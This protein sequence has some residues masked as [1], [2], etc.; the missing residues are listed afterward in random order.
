MVDRARA[1]RAARWV[2]AERQNRRNFT[3]LPA[4]LAPADA[5]EAYAAQALLQDLL[6]ETEGPVIGGK[7]ALTTPV[8]QKLTNYFHPVGAGILQR[9]VHWRTAELPLANYVRI[10]IECEVA[11]RLGRALDR[12]AADYTADSIAAAVDACMTGIEIVDDRA[13]DYGNL[14]AN[15]LIVDNA[16]NRGCVLATPV[17]DWRRLDLAKARGSVTIDGKEVGAGFGGDVMGAHPFASLA[18]LAN[19]AVKRGRPLAAG[20]IVLTGSLVVTQWPARG[21]QIVAAIEGLG[22]AQVKFV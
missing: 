13:A 2:L 5:E 17:T 4:A 9:D 15:T 3:A 6:A 14:D 12:A 16:M 21:Q 19:H 18:W 11:V 8:M 10:G 22:E 20:S 1:E 7:I